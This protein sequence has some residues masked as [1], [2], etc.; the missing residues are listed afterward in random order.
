MKR[1]RNPDA[2]HLQEDDNTAAEVAK[3]ACAAILD[4]IG[5]ESYGAGPVRDALIRVWRRT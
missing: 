3:I 5:E 2:A 1:R 4:H